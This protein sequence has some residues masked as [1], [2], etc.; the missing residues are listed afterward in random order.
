MNDSTDLNDLVY[1]SKEGRVTEQE[2]SQVAGALSSGD[3]GP[4]TYR[5]LY[6]IA[7][8]GARSHERLVA[9]F[10]SYRPDPAVAGLAL[11]ALCTFWGLTEKYLDEVERSLRGIEW[12]H[13]GDIR[14]IAITAAGEFLRTKPACSLLTELLR[15]TD[16][17]IEEENV[18]RFAVEALARAI[19]KPLTEVL[20]PDTDGTDWGDWAIQVIARARERF[21]TECA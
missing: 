13:N 1:R 21:E 19:G 3:G 16:R 7:R 18:R 6:V 14:R 4:D 17:E 15:L 20:D 5:L 9:Q 10:L 12:D 2:I 8:C 11:Q